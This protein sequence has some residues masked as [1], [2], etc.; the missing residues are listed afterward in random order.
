[1]AICG[2]T[3]HHKSS[4]RP[5]APQFSFLLTL[6]SQH[7][8]FRLSGPWSCCFW[9]RVLKYGVSWNEQMAILLSAVL[10]S[11]IWLILILPGRYHVY[12]RHSACEG[13]IDKSSTALRDVC[14]E[15]SKVTGSPRAIDVRK[16]NLNLVGQRSALK[17]R[18]VGWAGSL[19]R[20]S[21]TSPRM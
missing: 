20:D 1:M 15:E 5:W 9:T 8:T 7:H 4:R 11:F 2:A 19:F 12:V 3:W 16:P 13:S 14:Q 21:K 6:H 18:Q 17:N 10:P